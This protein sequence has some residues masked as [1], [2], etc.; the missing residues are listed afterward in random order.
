MFRSGKALKC[1]LPLVVDDSSQGNALEPVNRWGKLSVRGF[2]TSLFLAL[3][4]SFLNSNLGQILGLPLNFGYLTT[5]SE[6]YF[7]LNFMSVSSF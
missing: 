3:T 6:K 4:G 7:E 5:E 2:Q 1:V